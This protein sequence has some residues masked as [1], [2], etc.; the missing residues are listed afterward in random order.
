[1]ASIE[2]VKTALELSLRFLFVL[3]WLM[4]T[5]CCPMFSQHLCPVQ[6][7]KHNSYGGWLMDPSFICS[8]QMWV[9]MLGWL[10]ITLQMYHMLIDHLYWKDHLWVWTAAVNTH[11]NKN[12]FFT[13]FYERL[14][15]LPDVWFGVCQCQCWPWCLRWCHWCCWSSALFCLH[16]QLSPST[17]LVGSVQWKK[18]QWSSSSTETNWR[19]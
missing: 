14:E 18:K 8:A 1:M 4:C 17:W 16:V 7:M 2:S 15:K 3:L 10:V 9:I 19:R 12:V 5:F 13:E 11:S 6:T